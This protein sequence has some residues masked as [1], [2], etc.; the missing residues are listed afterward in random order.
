MLAKKLGLFGVLLATIICK[1]SIA[2]FPFVF[3]IGNK[4]LDGKGFLMVKQYCTHFIVTIICMIITWFA[5]RF[6]HLNGHIA[7]FI[8]ES[9]L[10]CLIVCIIF[11]ALYRKS[12]EYKF[13]LNKVI[14]MF[15]NFK[16]KR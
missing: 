12:D 5:C 1:Y 3:G 6:L 9:I 10:C 2:V 14:G 4:S 11:F 13:L 8:T 7:G 16:T 15:K